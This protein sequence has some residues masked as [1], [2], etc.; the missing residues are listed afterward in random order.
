[1]APLWKQYEMQ[2]ASSLR[3]HASPDARVI[4]DDR[5]KLKLPGRFSGVLRQIDVLVEGSFA[6]LP[7]ERR[8]LVD[9]KC[10]SRKI[11]IPHVE[12]F[13][14]MLDDVNVEMGL[15][16][17]TEGFTDAAKE[18]A[19]HV[20]GMI[21]D[22]VELDE[23]AKWRPRRPAVAHTSGTDTATLSYFDDDKLLTEV[24]SLDLA[25]RLIADDQ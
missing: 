23:L 13:A 8:M 15:L 10:F 19:R 4:F 18:R 20:R 22:V 24:V 12:A 21:I 6:G 16:V 2:I 17:T 5:G 25:R 7:G 11:D 3:Q 9:C 14:G 1:M